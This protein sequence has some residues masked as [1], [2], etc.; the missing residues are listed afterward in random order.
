MNACCWACLLCVA[1]QNQAENTHSQKEHLY[2]GSCVATFWF[3]MHPHFT[4]EVTSSTEL[5]SCSG[6]YLGAA[7]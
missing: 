5:H 2:L 6:G 7:V 3:L 4:Q 1:I